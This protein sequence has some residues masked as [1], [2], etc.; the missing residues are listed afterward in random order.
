MEKSSGNPKFDPLVDRSCVFLDGFCW[1]AK[2]YEDCKYLKNN[3]EET[4]KQ[5]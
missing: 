1:C 5:V 4:K 2:P 3:E